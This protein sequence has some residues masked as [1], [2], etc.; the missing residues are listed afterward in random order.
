MR[1]LIKT[2][3]FFLL[4]NISSNA[5]AS[6]FQADTIYLKG[7]YDYPPYHFLDKELKPTGF[8]IDIVNAIERT[9]GLNIDFEL[10]LWTKVRQELENNEIDGI[11][12]MSSSPER[13]KLFDFSTPYSYITHAIFV[14]KDSKIKTTD[15]LKDKQVIV[16]GTGCVL[17]V[18]Q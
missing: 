17:F 7:N 16:V 11:A 9:M 6:N 12:G 3:L 13:S 8:T 10:D 4:I 18:E 14:R 5:L 2:L 1:K 15:D